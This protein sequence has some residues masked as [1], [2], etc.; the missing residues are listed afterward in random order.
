MPEGLR[1]GLYGAVHLHHGRPAPCQSISVEVVFPDEAVF[2]LGLVLKLGED[3]Q[4]HTVLKK[5]ILVSISKTM[6]F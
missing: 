3:L 6:S 5:A 4:N 1:A 2:V